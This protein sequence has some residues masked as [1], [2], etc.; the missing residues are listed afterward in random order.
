MSKMTLVT[1]AQGR[2]V[3]AV[4][5]HELSA[6]RGDLSVQIS[7]PNG[8]KLHKLDVADDLMKITDPAAFEKAVAKHIPHR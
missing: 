6:K 2:F 1:D 3:G 5:G 4:E 7:F 8:H